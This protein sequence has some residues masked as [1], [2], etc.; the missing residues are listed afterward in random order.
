MTYNGKNYELVDKE[1]HMS[2]E[3][4]FFGRAIDED[5]NE[6]IVTIWPKNDDFDFHKECHAVV[7]AYDG[8]ALY[9]DEIDD[10]NFEIVSTE[11]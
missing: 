1:Y 10:E 7:D 11:W 3:N 9:A 6:T 2:G 8:C 5:G 4:S